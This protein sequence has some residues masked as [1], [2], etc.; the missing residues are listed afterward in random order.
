M[1]R[2]NIKVTVVEKKK[3]NGHYGGIRF[4]QTHLVSN[5][6]HTLHKEMHVVNC[7][8]KE[9]WFINGGISSLCMSMVRMHEIVGRFC[10][11]PIY[12]NT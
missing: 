11:I 7:V 3:K 1:S 6:I 2:S 10:P 5:C 4:S 8:T 9:H 12:M